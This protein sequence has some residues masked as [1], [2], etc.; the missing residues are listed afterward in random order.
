MI[1][2]SNLLALPLFAPLDGWLAP[3]DELPD[4]VFAGR[5]LGDGIAIDPTGDTLYAPCDALVVSVAATAHA[6]TLRLDCG[7]E[8]L[9]HLGIDTV[10]MGGLGF[11]PLVEAGARVIARQPLIRFDLDAV[12][13]GASSAMT[14]MLLLQH[15]AWSVGTL[16]GPGPVTAGD[17][18]FEIVARSHSVADERNAETAG[19]D[20]V[21]LSRTIP[22]PLRHGIHARPAARLRECAMQF[23]AVVRMEH[24]GRSASLRS[25]VAMLALGVRLR[26]SLTLIASGSE[27]FAALD[28]L[29]ALIASGMGELAPPEEAPPP[30]LAACVPSRADAEPPAAWPRDNA[31]PG[32][33]ASP[34]I[35]VGQAFHLRPARI[36]A[37]S[38]SGDPAQEQAFL[39]ATLDALSR[40]MADDQDQIAP[41]AAEMLTAH[42]AMLEDEELRAAAHQAIAEGASAGAGWRDAIGFQIAVLTGSGDPRLAERADDLRD[43]EQRVLAALA[44]VEQTRLELPPGTVLIAQDLLPSQLMN[45]DRSCLSAIALAQGGPTSHVAILAAGMGVPMLVALGSLVQTIADGE[46]LV[47]DA[48][49]GRL[50]AQPSP[51]RIAKVLAQREIDAERSRAARENDAPCCSSDGTRIKVFANLS[52]PADAELALANGAEGSGLVRSEFLFAD[53]AQAPGVA[54]QLQAYQTIARTLNDRPIIVRLLDIGGDK[55]VPFLPIGGEENPALGLRGIRVG[56]AYPALLEAQIEA[57]LQVR[58]EGQC[59]IMVPM[60]ASLSELRQVRQVVDAV[61]TRLELVKRVQVGIMVETPAAAA[62]ADLLAQEAD[63]LSIGTNDLTQYTLAM[64][65]GNAR[66]AAMIDGL[67]PAVLRLIAQTCE[68]AAHHGR[69][70]GVCGSLASDPAAVPLLLGLGVTELSASPALVAEIKALVMRLSL[71]DCRY[72][73]LQALQCTSARDVRALASAFEGSLAA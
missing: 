53:R 58:P 27:A 50:E 60:V 21:E 40:R 41:H 65:R 61:A 56:L 46:Q 5:L 48:R 54:E 9:L 33:C 38:S 47:I 45:L 68:G 44:G 16:R 14:P 71:D 43:L 62:T 72:L 18:V 19:S 70:V 30:G 26:D 13:L 29:E 66:V 17:H 37:P 73:A 7:A 42:R 4:P 55:P 63:F 36:E 32:V 69:W 52:S 22:V 11:T 23:D 57:I 15:D 3:L 24:A 64:D 59:R 31:L 1:P 2:A 20:P 34:G 67:H 49:A 39:D 51:E 25:P 28:A 35:A 8:L 6:V 12:V 10:A